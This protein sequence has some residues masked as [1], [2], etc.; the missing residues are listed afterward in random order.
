MKNKQ[1][2]NSDAVSFSLMQTIHDEPNITQR[3]LADKLGLSLGKV[4]YCIK[5]LVDK[6]LIKIDNFR[7]SEAKWRY[8]YV[9]TP[10]GF[11]AKASLT[12]QFLECKLREFEDLQAQIIM[13]QAEVKTTQD[14]TL[15]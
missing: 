5:A 6:G 15:T 3:E 2:S 11:A 10:K 12:R 4:N 13:L 1:I 14:S 9:L 7:A 8:M